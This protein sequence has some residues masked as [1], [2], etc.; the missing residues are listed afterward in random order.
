MFD[1][2]LFAKLQLIGSKSEGPIYLLQG[3][4]YSE[5]PVVKAAALWE[6]DPKLHPF[7]G[8]KVTITGKF[9]FDGIHYQKI[10]ALPG[11]VKEF[12]EEAVPRKL[13][14]DLKTEHEILYVNK[15]P[16]APS[17][18]QSMG[19]SLLVK[20]PYRSI[21]RGSC[22]TSQVYDFF[23]EKDGEMLWQW[24]RGQVFLMTVTLVHIPGGDFVEYSV[25]WLFRPEEIPSEGGYTAR[26]VFIASRQEVTK[27]FQVR[28]AV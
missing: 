4:D 3:W 22:P 14:I 17:P 16:P 12:E 10:A 6:N 26:A 23:I 25:Q 28:F 13:V 24:S 5:I 1:G 21:W 11:V 20:W 9:G 7:L 8:Q 2:Y 15:M 18:L 27:T 19:L